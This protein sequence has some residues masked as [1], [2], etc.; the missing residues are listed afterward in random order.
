MLNPTLSVCWKWCTAKIPPAR[1][2]PAPIASKHCP[3]VF[4][5][6]KLASGKN[7]PSNLLHT[8]NFMADSWEIPQLK[9]HRK[10]HRNLKLEWVGGRMCRKYIGCLHEAQSVCNI[11]PGV[12]T[13]KACGPSMAWSIY[14]SRVIPQPCEFGTGC[15]GTVST[16]K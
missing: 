8:I 16:S 5:S 15:K 10:S 4:L 9:N 1:G 12:Y 13:I 2:L 7:E 3:S 14:P 11:Q 6:T